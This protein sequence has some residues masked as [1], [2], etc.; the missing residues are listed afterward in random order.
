MTS[1]SKFTIFKP[2]FC[3]NPDCKLHFGGENFY[4]LN[5]FSK[6]S[7]APYRNQ[8][9]RCNFCL[10]QFS[11]NTFSLDF[12][13]RL[14]S[15]SENIL[16]MSMNGM[17]NCSIAR[18]LKIRERVIRNRQGLLSRQAKLF[19]K[20][21]EMKLKIQEPVCYDGF[22]TFSNSQFSPCYINTAIG[23]KSLYTFVVSFSP[24]NRKGRMTAWQQKK[25]LKLQ[26]EFGKYPQN[27]VTKLTE[28]TYEKLVE[29]ADKFPMI[30][31]TDEHK[32]YEYV[33]KTK[34]NHQ[35]S[36]HQT[37]SKDKRDTRNPLFPVNH[38]HLTYRHFLASQRRETIAFN[39][40]EA[41]LMDRMILMKVYKNFM[42]PKTLRQ[43]RAVVKSPA[44]ELGL[45]DRILKFDDIFSERRF[46]THYN[47]DEVEEKIYRRE[48][49]Y[50]RQKI[51]SHLGL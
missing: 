3:P 2:A 33:L 41:G 6:T 8:R 22:E 38:L 50:S 24:L 47:L 36:H 28:Y 1:K 40:N 21:S 37:N 15:I 46:K 51:Q 49:E 12:R 23:K 16:I 29:R 44:M 10:R 32:S 31:H 14:T 35:F 5:G 17:T 43:R 11:K 9:Y 45:A 26:K 39:K 48:Y 42:R 13:K 27:S 4:K 25:N 20:Q 18:N 30:L 7:K 34:F 19:E